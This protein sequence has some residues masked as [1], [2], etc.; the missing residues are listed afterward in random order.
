MSVPSSDRC[1][2]QPLA[3]ELQPQ[4]LS[5]QPGGKQPSSHRRHPLL[6]CISFLGEANEAHPALN[7]YTGSIWY[8]EAISSMRNA[9]VSFRFLALPL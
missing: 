8:N 6:L 9:D 1:S 3:N 2:L 5:E 7:N 4:V